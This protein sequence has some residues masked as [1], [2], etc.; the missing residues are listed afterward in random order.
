[1]CVCV[2]VTGGRYQFARVPPQA[3]LVMLHL[4]IR[5]NSTI[6]N[7]LAEKL[8]I[9]TIQSIVA[10]GSKKTVFVAHTLKHVVAPL[11]TLD[12][13][14]RHR[15]GEGSP[16]DPTGRQSARTDGWHGERE[17]VSGKVSGRAG[18]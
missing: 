8:A 2:C 17:T 4:S 13:E 16:R 14:H 15:E 6:D 3:Y 10:V 9:L 1:M 7:Q 12:L 11:L 18:T 5:F